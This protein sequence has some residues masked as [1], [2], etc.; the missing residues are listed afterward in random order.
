MSFDAASTPRTEPDWVAH[1]IW[2]HVYPLGF[3]DAPQQAQPDVTHRFTRIGDWLDYAIELGASGILL[4]P[5]FASETHGYDTVDYFAIDN[6][7]GDEDD[8]RAFAARAHELGIRILLDGVFNHVGRAFPAFQNAL[9]GGPETALFRPAPSIDDGPVDAAA[10]RFENFEGH[11]ALVALNHANPAVADLV[12]RVMNHWLDAGADGWRL[13]AAYSVDPAFWAS[14]LPRVRERHPDAYIVGE[15]IHGDYAAIIT[16]STMDS[17]TQ[18]EAWKAIRNA[19]NERN[20]FELA[21]TLERHNAFLD[22]FVPMTFVGNHDVTR[23]ASAIDDPRHV[24]H[25][26]VTLLTIGGTPAIYYG[27]ERGLLGI[28]E[29]R[30]GG[31]DAV[32]PAMPEGGP[33]ALDDSGHELLEVHRQLIGIRRRNAWLHTARTTA[34]ITENDVF[35]YESRSSGG[36]SY[37]G[38]SAGGDGTEVGG[39]DRIV[40]AL[41]LSDG[42]AEYG[43]DGTVGLLAGSARIEQRNAA[44]ILIIEPHGWAI[45]G[46]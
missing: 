14:V 32:R 34:H 43:T 5:I 36:A 8:F 1:A 29:D 20:F 3:V 38:G 24:A 15:V 28:K 41:N 12:L 39:D 13:D 22:A 7:L 21:W 27:D 11:D 35:V 33:A 19:I 4:G 25:A 40:V 26:I 44:S 46:R 2:W 37:A 30:A 9:A 18:Y 16:E 42:P 45:L 31:D 23:I 17:V 10:P 6:R